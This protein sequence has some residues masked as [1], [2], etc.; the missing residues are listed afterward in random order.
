VELQLEGVLTA[1]LRVPIK[2]LEPRIVLVDAL[3]GELQAE[4]GGERSCQR[5]LARSN[6]PRDADEHAVE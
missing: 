3:Q 5:R 4:S 1:A 6:H 2:E